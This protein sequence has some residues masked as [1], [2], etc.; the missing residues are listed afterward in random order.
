MPS[1]SVVR[2]L[3]IDA[4]QAWL[5]GFTS[6]K[7]AHISGDTVTHCPFWIVTIWNTILDIR[8]QVRKPWTDAT[9]WVRKQLQQKKKADVRQ[10]AAETSRP[11]TMLPWN[12]AKRGLSSTDP[13]H[14][15]WRFLGSTWLSRTK[16]V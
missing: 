12:V 1:I 11:L 3:V 10:A 8:I 14:T 2:R 15:L 4:K 6:V 5:D 13:I 7:Y 9:D 16:R